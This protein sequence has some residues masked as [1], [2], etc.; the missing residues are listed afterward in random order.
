MPGRRL[1]SAP[2]CPQQRTWL[3][4][5]LLGRPLSPEGVPAARGSRAVFSA[6][7]PAGC[8]RLAART[9]SRHWALATR[10]TMFELCRLRGEQHLGQAGSILSS[11]PVPGIFP[12]ACWQLRLSLL[13]KV[14]ALAH[15]PDRPYFYCLFLEGEIGRMGGWM[16]GRMGRCVGGWMGGQTDGQM[17]R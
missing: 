2:P 6:R 14:M 10:G 7:D 16:K 12:G 1:G 13:V 9:S 3:S 17:D 4:K 15:F 8:N 11:L 5:P